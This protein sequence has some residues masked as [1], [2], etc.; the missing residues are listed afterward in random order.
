MDNKLAF[1]KARLV[2]VLGS[3]VLFGP[4]FFAVTDPERL[5]IALLIIPFIWLF[6]VLFWIIRAVLSTKTAANK[7]QSGYIAS[8]VASLPVLLLLFQSIHQLA[9]RDVVLSV[10]IV[11]LAA[12]YMFRADF[13]K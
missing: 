12:I 5:P 4:I 8:L 3:V 7:R 2:I 1:Q 11:A 9:F 10:G 13:I 6:G